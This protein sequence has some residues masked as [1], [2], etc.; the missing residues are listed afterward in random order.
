MNWCRHRRVP[1]CCRLVP[2]LAP[3]SLISSNSQKLGLN[4][5]LALAI[6]FQ[7]LNQNKIGLTVCQILSK[8]FRFWIKRLRMRRILIKFFKILRMYLDGHW[9]RRTGHGFGSYRSVRA[10]IKVLC[11][12]GGGSGL[13]YPMRCRVGKTAAEQHWLR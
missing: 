7:N 11:V 4:T 10:T 6:I 9:L 12:S 2:R 13:P 3:A 5:H 1:R 8:Y